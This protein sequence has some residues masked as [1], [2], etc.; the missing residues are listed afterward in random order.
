MNNNF[1]ALV[2]N[3]DENKKIY[4]SI[5]NRSIDQLPKGDVLIRVYYSSINY[6]DILS[7]SGN[8]GVTRKYPHTPGID[9]AGIVVTSISDQFKKGDKVIV[10][11][12]DL[13]MNT[14]G[15]F[16]EYISVPSSWISKLPSNLTLKESMILG[17]AGFTAGI[18][19][20]ELL[21]Q[22]IT[23]DLGPIIVSGATGGLGSIAINILSKLGYFVI[24]SS[25]KAESINFL[26]LIGSSEIV[27][28]DILD[29]NSKMPQL[30]E[31]WIAGIDTLGGN[32]LSTMIK[33]CKKYGTIISTGNIASQNLETS[34][35]PFILRGIKLIGINSEYKNN[36]ERDFIWKQLAN[37]WKPDN[38]QDIVTLCPLNDLNNKIDNF[39]NGRQVGRVVV[40]LI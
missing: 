26:K 17:T 2:V 11:S 10:I 18:C 39:L 22:K 27:G 32:S 6:K 15:G 1:K 14:P 31:R 35:L 28:R 7:A 21:Y 19:I 34:I 13:G 38:L 20:Q 5:I 29:D 12:H 3:F 24:A 23:P 40:S 30:K 4:R 36:L 16:G 33:S 9:A 25:G 37:A 8:L